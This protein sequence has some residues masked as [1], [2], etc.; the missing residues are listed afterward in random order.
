[1]KV[2]AFVSTANGAGK[3]TL[4]AH[5][6]VQAHRC[7]AGPVA[8]ID[9]DPRGNLTRWREARNGPGPTLVEVDHSHIAASWSSPSLPLSRSRPPWPR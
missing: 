9:A 5:I 7:D 4:A 3:T 1:M 8:M 2:L 6:A